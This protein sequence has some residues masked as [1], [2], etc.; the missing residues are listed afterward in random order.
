MIACRTS[1]SVT[2]LLLFAGLNTA[3]SLAAG[4]G[5]EAFVQLAQ[6]NPEGQ[7]GEN[8]KKKERPKEQP[9]QQQRAAPPPQQQQRAAPQPPQQ[10]P[11][12]QA[13]AAER[14]EQRREAPVERRQAQPERKPEAPPKQV[15]PPERAA[16]PTGPASTPPVQ[17]AAPTL[18]KP[19]VKSDP[20]Q[21]RRASPA[22]K[23][24]VPFIKPT[25]RPIG[26]GPGQPRQAVPATPDVKTPPVA[27]VEKKAGAPIG[28]S[29]TTT[30]PSNAA[31]APIVVPPSNTPPSNAA[32]S[33][34]PAPGTPPGKGATPPANP[35]GTVGGTP[36]APTTAGGVP[37]PS[38]PA[39]KPGAPPALG[40]AVGGVAIGAAGAAVAAG[41]L[42]PPV[43]KS[44]QAQTAP[45]KFEDVQKGRQQRVEDGGRR[46]IIQE[47]GNRII[48]K[49]DNRII[50]Q[51]D[52]AERFRR[53]KDSQTQRRPDGIVETFYVRPDGF[54]VVTEV[55]GSGR[56]LRR[57]RRGPDGREFGIID[58]RRFYQNAAIGIGIGAIAVAI[59]LNLA[60]PRITIPRERYIVD[61]DRVSDDDLYETLTAPPVERLERSYSLEEVRYS[62]ELREHMRRVDLNDVT[63]AFGAYEI[64]QEQ[65]PKLER[66]AR[67]ILRAVRENPEEVFLIEGHTDAVGSDVDNL[68]LSDRRAAAVAQVLSETF[69]V[70]PENLVTQGYGEQY[71][72]VKTQDAER[73][74]RR[75]AARRI[76]PLMAEK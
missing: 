18:D 23:G 15:V 51:H 43:P 73:A 39:M 4:N 67:S 30:P 69:G 9:P 21:E 47:P 68:S 75:V 31:G 62:Y 34:I 35:P 74:N 52:E 60:P 24:A 58:N 65:Y 8:D 27:P 61:Y 12:R 55:D 44:P 26:S 17:R 76:T 46:T 5:G 50:I 25:D 32:G 57:F 49:Q 42:A 10:K 20:A 3:P 2:V 22:D 14:R 29:P 56:L 1:V 48:I 37:A 71:L 64:G 19:P 6:A 59:A 53:V 54:R 36:Q 72:K 45:Q 13:P 38:T 66:L 33:I 63:F 7:K 70:P 40:A 16:R 28:V 11:E 41:A